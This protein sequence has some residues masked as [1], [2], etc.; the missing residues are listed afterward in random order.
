MLSEP[1]GRRRAQTYNDMDFW[2]NAGESVYRPSVTVRELLGQPN[3]RYLA[4][5]LVEA[6]DESGSGVC[7]RARCLATQTMVRFEARRLVLAAG[8]LGTARIALRS[9]ALYDQ[10]LP[11]TCNPHTY[12]PSVLVG[13]VGTAQEDRRHSLA[14]LTMIFD[15]TGDKRHLVQSQVFSYRSLMLLR[16]LRE[17]PLAYRET[18]RIMRTLA[19]YMAVWLIQHEDEQTSAKACSLRRRPDGSEYLEIAYNLSKSEQDAR[20]AREK[21][22]R[23]AIRR[24]GCFPLKTVHAMA[25]SSAHYASQLSMTAEDRPMTTDP[26]G[27]LRGTQFSYIADGASFAYLPAKGLTLTLMANANRVGGNVVARL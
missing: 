16:L 24:L 15:P 23:R 3:F 1:L 13:G 22:M 9:F 6:F 10:P 5:H 19:P 25:G 26:T 12:V 18:L 14:Q 4:S 8:A 27:R 17:S 20:V 11:L 2:S 7:V 21:A